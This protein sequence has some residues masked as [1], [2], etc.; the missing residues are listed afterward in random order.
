LLIIITYNDCTFFGGGIAM[1]DS[2]KD[3]IKDSITTVMPLYSYPGEQSI[4]PA[5]QD[6]SDVRCPLKKSEKRIWVLRS[7]FILATGVK[8][9]NSEYG[10]KPFTVFDEAV[11]Q[12]P[13]KYLSLSDRFGHPSIAYREGEYDGS[14]YYA[15][16]VVQR[17][18]H[19]VVY[20]CSG[21]FERDDLSN[22]QIKTLEMYIAKE[23]L[24]AYGE[25]DIRFYDLNRL[26]ESRE[27]S[28]LFG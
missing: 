22:Q 17:A 13:G 10:Y 20:L 11:Q 24:S 3:F 1:S 26:Q 9:S 19:L 21:R 5:Y 2:L 18:D 28:M 12:D 16:W 27:L 23:F 8:N 7:D 14:V 25:Q 6:I 4:N 15:G